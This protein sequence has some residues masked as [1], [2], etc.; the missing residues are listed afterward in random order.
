MSAQSRLFGHEL[1]ERLDVMSPQSSRPST[2]QVA[3][4]PSSGAVSRRGLGRV[5]AR[6]PITVFLALVFGIGWPIE[7]IAVLSD[8]G[9][10]P[11][12]RLPVEVFALAVTLLV[13]LP[14]AVWVTWACD[15]R[16]GVNALFNRTFRWRFG[17]G[18]WAVV[19][20]G[21]PICTLA[22]GV[23]IGGSL[24]TTDLPSILL[25][26]MLSIV[27]AVLV[28]NLWEETVWAGFM[29]T[30]LEYRYRLPVAAALT[31]VPFAGIHMPLLLIGHFTAASLL[32]GVGGLLLLGVLVRLMIGVV[33]RGAADSLLAVG[34]LHQLFDSSNNKEQLVD[35]L[36]V[37]ADQSVLVLPATALLTV[38]AAVIL[39]GRLGRRRA[40]RA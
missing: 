5:A 38:A 22:L 29:Q 25:E 39:K 30:R 36:L 20:L 35:K 3:V 31:S 11:G 18:W 33:L 24:H 16:Q 4:R 10:L 15:D 6:R 1:T 37:G 28:I 2:E 23:L 13:M 8:H 21:L 14:A 17:I 27:I 7:A 12:G 19:L 26:Q 9:M 34:I 40:P 32:V